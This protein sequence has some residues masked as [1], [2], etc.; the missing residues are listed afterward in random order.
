MF[1]K[2]IGSFKDIVLLGS[3]SSRT[4]ELLLSTDKCK[5]W[6]NVQPKE[7]GEMFYFSFS[8]PDENNIYGLCGEIDSLKILEGTP[9]EEMLVKSNLYLIH[10]IDQGKTWERIKI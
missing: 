9:A 10:S 3:R 6:N 1:T 8:I 4:K 5:T 2:T 7:W